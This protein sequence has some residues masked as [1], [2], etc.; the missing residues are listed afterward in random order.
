MPKLHLTP[1]AQMIFDQTRVEFTYPTPPTPTRVVP[2]VKVTKSK[3]QVK[4]KPDRSAL[5]QEAHNSNSLNQQA[6][7]ANSMNQQSHTWNS[8]VSVEVKPKPVSQMSTPQQP[9][10]KPKAKVAVQTPVPQQ[11]PPVQVKSRPVS[12][13]ST[14]QLDSTPQPRSTLQVVLPRYPSQQSQTTPSKPPRETP[15]LPPQP[16]LPLKSTSDPPNS[17][18]PTGSNLGLAIVIPNL[19][20][21]FR[22]EDYEV[23]PDSP[24]TPQHLSRKRHQAENEEESMARSVDQR[25]KADTAFRHLRDYFLEIFE[26]EDQVQP[27]SVPSSHLLE[28]ASDG[29]TLSED[30]QKRVESL[31]K[32]VIDVGRF[33]EAPLDDL[34]RIQKLSEGA[35]K[36]AENVDVK[37]DDAMG[38]EEVDAV[39][40]QFPIAS[41][42]LKAGKTAL[43]LMC[44]GREEKQLY[45]E[46]L[47][48]AALNVF[49]N[50]T[51]KCIV[52]I[53]EMRSSGQTAGVFKLFSAHKKAII[54]ILTQCRTLL[55]IMV[56]L[57]GSLE[58]SETVINTL[59]FT[60][61]Q[62]IFVE[63]SPTE[64]DSVLGVSKFDSLRVVAMDIIA[65]IF[66]GNPTARRGIFDE[67][68]TSLERL[69]VTK[70]S[71]RQFKLPEGGSIQLVSALIMKLVQTSACN[72]DDSKT[73][74]RDKVLKALD[75]GETDAPAQ[76][77]GITITSEYRA[78]QQVVTSIQELQRTAEP[79]L[80]SARHDAGYV[81]HFI[82]TRAMGSSKTG[83]TPYR[84]L[85]D[86]FVEDFITCLSSTDWPAAEL[87]LRLL[88]FK[89]VQ[90]AEGDKTPAPAKN[91]ALDSLGSMGAAISEL[92][93]HVRKAAASVEAGDGGLGT[94]L[95]R[96][97]E[98]SLEKTALSSDLISWPCGPF[99]ATVEYLEERK[100]TQLNSALSLFMAEWASKIYTSYD[101]LTGE[102]GQDI[103]REYA[104][105]AYRV[106][107][108]ITDRRW[109]ST[110]YSFDN[111]PTSHA[112][113]AYS[114]TVLNSS[115]CQSFGRIL[116]ILLQSMSS[117]QATVRS[118][119]LKSV[120]QL[121]DTDPSILDRE[122]TVLRLIL[123]CSNDTSVQ[124]RD[125]ALGLIGKCINLRPKLEEDVLDNFLLPRISDAAVSVRKRAIKLSKDIYLRNHNSGVRSR[126]AGHLLHRV[127]DLDESVQ[128]LARQTIED[129]WM[130]PFYQSTLKGDTSAQY[131]LDISEHV[132]LM[133]KTVHHSGVATVLEKVL[134][135]M[136]TSTSKPM[137]A[138]IRVCKALVATMFDTII[139]NSGKEG[140]E[141]T[142]ARDA[143][144]ILE[145]FAKSNNQLFTPDQVHLL[146][147]YLENVKGGEDM[148][149][150]RSIVIIY[151]HVLPNLSVAYSGFLVATRSSLMSTI[152]R[153]PSRIVED[154]VACLWIISE[155]LDDLRHLTT[156][157]I[158]SLKNIR[159]FDNT[160]FADPANATPMKKACK[161]LGIVGIVGKYCD[162][163]GQYDSIKASFP[164]WRNKSVST[165]MTD[166][167]A[168]FALAGQPL[169]LRKA[170]LEA[171]GMV[172]QSWPKNF[173]N[174]NIKTTCKEV[175]QSETAVLETIIMK[176]FKDFLLREEKRSEVGSD[177]LPGGASDPSAKLG[178]MGGGHGDGIALGLAQEFLD[179]IKAIAIRSLDDQALLATEV[180]ASITRQG[181]VHPKEC[182][183]TM[184]ALETSSNPRIA[185]VA[186]QE[187]KSA[188]EKHET[189]LEKEYMTAVK[190]AYVYQRDVVGDTHGATLNPFVSKLH[191]MI[192]VLKISKP[193]NRKRFYDNLCSRLEFPAKM[194]IVQDLPH[195]LEFSQFIIENMAFFEYATMDEL[196][197]AVS[198]MDRVVN[199]T[200]TAI[201]HAIETEIFHVSLDQPS[202]VDE[203]G[204]SH[205]VQP[206]TDP[207]R[208]TELTASSMMLSNLWATRTY[209]RRQYGLVT[210]HG[211][212]KGVAKDLNKAPVRVQ[213]VNGDKYWE[214][215][216]LTMSALESEESMFRQCRAFVDVLSIDADFKLAAEA[217]EDMDKRLETPSDN[218]E[219]ETPGPPGSG[220]GRKR[221]TGAAQG[222][223]RKKR[224]R[225]SSVGPRGRGRA[226]GNGRQTSADKS[227]D[228][229]GFD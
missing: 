136:L 83:D 151:R 79:L 94:Y 1:V 54:D 146:Q 92:N 129:V 20:S 191:M 198:A 115:F 44:G 18:A 28:V 197:S 188:H 59:E 150:F 87:L 14:P 108:M 123:A 154:V 40:R 217:D 183:P 225:S 64:R 158:S 214:E 176:A 103:E 82:V 148:V 65:Q 130:S 179:F 77:L 11:Q 78:E 101:S 218:E 173:A 99:R 120:N 157:T 111:V 5:N 13:T 49:K 140:K 76:S 84:N 128:E 118:K 75:D 46:E 97:A 199:S 153:F 155:V 27:D 137:E 7:S 229:E 33:G 215:I 36:D 70:Q 22:A 62:L 32:K 159:Q 147:P 220:R 81:V 121:L 17:S 58:L 72:P 203:N 168:P 90:L 85:F 67:I 134:K 45:S 210:S 167:F 145:I 185:E 221:K 71:A 224:A 119:S 55:K 212:V 143:L 9:A 228:G 80:D 39:I 52:P 69:P 192:D 31:L 8:I 53:V 63:N 170:A 171:I 164:N 24:D 200:G 38:H 37:I 23:L 107:N 208:L 89:M 127:T 26:A 88:L 113:L 48:Q 98:T 100:D 219:N 227:D 175:F 142:T 133:I 174:A 116:T 223:T 21:N 3:S 25:E 182:G 68:L 201:Q 4:P 95:A 222:G 47:I 206:T 15:I 178:V 105:L 177:G 41:L 60:A 73:K 19:P 161:L 110:E 186:F 126:I 34:I 209:L 122:P 106:R 202:Q 43:R 144:R 163:D 216:G 16:T 2:D 152:T 56:S 117:E 51:E 187:H 109:L 57:I 160:N 204:V 10:V 96:L 42:G 207:M 124:V 104:R 6:H 29:L 74:R 61:S 125:S 50:V 149:I 35:L 184:I 156:V 93:S 211:K 165:L 138:N 196:F 141:S 195:H 66:Q 132:N 112:R 172:C 30:A 86:L 166:T 114:L 12:Q 169:E 102:D 226:K 193:K 180:I 190:M 213:G 139:D 131:K 162:L 194:D 91:M 135:G 181:L 189:I 205:P